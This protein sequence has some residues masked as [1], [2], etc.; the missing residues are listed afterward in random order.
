MVQEFLKKWSVESDFK[1]PNL[2]LSLRLKVSGCHYNS[3]YNNTWIKQY[4][5]YH[6]SFQKHG[7]LNFFLCVYINISFK[8]VH[9]N[10]NINIDFRKAHFDHDQAFNIML[11]KE[12]LTTLHTV[13]KELWSKIFGQHLG[14]VFEIRLGQNVNMYTNRLGH[15]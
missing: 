4:L 10:L 7:V 1:A 6:L 11:M 5:S 2:P 9:F 8:D 14:Y 3:I 15:L 13:V 12:T